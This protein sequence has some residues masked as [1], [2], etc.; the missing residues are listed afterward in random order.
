MLGEHKNEE[1][2]VGLLL[3]LDGI[4]NRSSE[5]SSKKLKPVPFT[6]RNCQCNGCKVAE[7]GL[8][9]RIR[10]LEIGV[11]KI[12]VQRPVGAAQKLGVPKGG[13]K[14]GPTRSL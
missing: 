14:G 2:L 6:S 4:E 13:P 7:P 3:F 1:C 8:K 12:K 5:K 11:Q 9:F 10:F